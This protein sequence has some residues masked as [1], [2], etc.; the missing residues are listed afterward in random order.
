MHATL[1]LC[2][3]GVADRPSLLG[4]GGLRSVVWARARHLQGRQ[5]NMSKALA[6]GKISELSNQGTLDLF[7]EGFKLLRGSVE[8]KGFAKGVSEGISGLTGSKTTNAPSKFTPGS[9]IDDYDDF[10]DDDFESDDDDS[11]EEDQAVAA[12]EAAEEQYADEDEGFMNR[13]GKAKSEALDRIGLNSKVFLCEVHHLKVTNLGRRKR[14][15]QV[16]GLPSISPISS[17]SSTS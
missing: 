8:D 14:D 4:G 3:P 5:W 17:R 7:T 6:G 1:L 11:Y 10:E 13:F 9:D 16:T 12:A 2:P 15:I